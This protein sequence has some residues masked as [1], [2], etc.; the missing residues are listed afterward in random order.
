MPESALNERKARF[1]TMQNTSMK[2]EVADRVRTLK[3]LPTLR[4]IINE[5]LAIITKKDAS[6]QELFN[7]VKYDQAI[8]SKIL[9][10]ANSAYY[11]RGA[12]VA[13]LERA[14]IAI[15]FD[16]IKKIIMCVVFLKEILGAWNLSPRDLALLWVHSLSVGCAAKILNTHTASE[17]AETVFT[18]SILHDIGKV[19]FC[20]FGEKYY[21]IEEDARQ[22]NLD[23]CDLEREEFG[24]DHQSVGFFMSKKWGFPDEISKVIRNH[25]GP[26]GTPGSLL[27]IIRAADTF[28]DRPQA[29]AGQEGA[30][31][32][33]EREKIADETRRI[34]EYLNV[35]LKTLPIWLI[36]G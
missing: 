19:V 4:S 8:T 18:A 11:S 31:L 15:G 28:I 30:I 24:L 16:E 6:L 36:M 33:G 22:R 25:H 5:L 1:P 2:E 29:D 27:H 17:S 7:V 35:D 12:N 21:K 32:L 14:M 34:S 9:T 20:T 26:S 13:D 23:I 10:V 3:V